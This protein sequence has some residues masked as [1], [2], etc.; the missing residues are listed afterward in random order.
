MS[1]V[2][3]EPRGMGQV[4]KDFRGIAKLSEMISADGGIIRGA[5][6]SSPSGG[7]LRP[8]ANAEAPQ[9]GWVDGRIRCR[10]GRLV[11][12]GRIKPGGAS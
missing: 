7:P 4:G 11:E 12:V 10:N 5:A 8:S 2:K 6:A 3:V 1:G 9:T